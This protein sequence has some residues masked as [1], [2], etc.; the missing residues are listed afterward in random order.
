MTVINLDPKVTA[1]GPEGWT[2]ATVFLYATPWAGRKEAARADGADLILPER[3][4]TQHSANT[5]LQLTPNDLKW[6][7]KITVESADQGYSL[8]RYVNVPAGTPIDWEDLV[9]VDPLTMLVNPS[10]TAV[11][12]LLTQIEELVEGIEPGTGV[13]SVS[14]GTTPPTNTTP[15]NLYIQKAA[16]NG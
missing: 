2:A 10:L 7:W 13:P 8:T 16:L 5:I 9:D 14:F 3:I 15:G 11:Q 1:L 4:V 6:C 12:A